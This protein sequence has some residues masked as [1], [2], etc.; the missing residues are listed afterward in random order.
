VLTENNVIITENYVCVCASKL[1][2]K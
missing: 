1:I 2:L